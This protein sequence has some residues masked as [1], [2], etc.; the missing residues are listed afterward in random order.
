MAYFNHA[1]QKC[2]LATADTVAESGTPGQSGGQAGITN[3]ILTTTGVHVSNLKSTSSAEGYQIGKGVLGIFDAK[4]HLSVEASDVGNDCCPFYIANASIKSND[5][6]GPFH[7]GYQESNKSKIINPKYIRKTYKVHSNAANAAFLQI[8]GTPDNFGGQ[9]TALDAGSLS[10]GTGYS[11]AVDVPVTGG[12]GMG[13]TVDITQTA[14]VID[15]VAINDPGY[16]YTAGDT[17]TITTGNAD[18][19]IDVDTVSAQGD[20]CDKEFLCGEQY[21]IRVEAKGADALRFANHN[22]YRD[23]MADGGCC[24]DPATPVAVTDDVIYLQWATQI[25]EDNYLKDFIRPVLVVDGQSYAYDADAATALGLDPATELFSDAPAATMSAGIILIGAYQETKFGNCTFVPTDYYSVE[26][27]QIQVSEVD[28]NGDPC[29][30]GGV[31]VV[32]D[33]KG[34]QASGLGETVIR[35]VLLHESYLQNFMAD[36]LRIREITQGTDIFDVVDRESLYS[37]FYILH[38]VPRY[39][40]PTGVFDND[41]YLLEIFGASA[42]ADDL[43]TFFDELGADGCTTCPATDDY[44]VTPCTHPALP[45]PEDEA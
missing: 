28:L 1:F 9:V 42:M 43:E 19:T 30:W 20:G 17:V 5:M 31:C 22:L 45:N 3:G 34:V 13:L 38:S 35:N 4:T 11:D 14:G 29:T 37:A 36:D 16:G 23:L 7:G 33:C 12:T 6:Q 41:Q 10:A 25:A 15:T 21:Y 8:G 27:I 32:T 2:F 24:A 44:T 40:N 18:A 26:P 39:N